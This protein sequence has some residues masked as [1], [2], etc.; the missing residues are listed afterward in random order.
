L[1]GKSFVEA[2][3]WLARRIRIGTHCPLCNGFAKI[4]RRKITGSMAASLIVLYFEHRRRRSW[5]SWIHFET[6]TAS[7]SRKAALRVRSRMLSVL[8]FWKLVECKTKGEGL[9]GYFRITPAGRRFVEEKLRVR[10][11][12][13]I[14]NNYGL[15]LDGGK[16]GI[17][18]VMGEKFD[19]EELMLT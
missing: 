3:R 1:Q 5:K 11:S 2:R 17:T 13:Y 18:D 9:R 7:L 15:G 6:V 4:Y 10:R 8:R 14:Y 12:A 19:Y 16:V